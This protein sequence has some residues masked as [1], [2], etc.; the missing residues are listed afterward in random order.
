MGGR[1]RLLC[2]IDYE[3]TRTNNA[4]VVKRV[5]IWLRR[6]NAIALA[7][8]DSVR[9]KHCSCWELIRKLVGS[10]SCGNF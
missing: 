4:V 5:N 9:D 6:I 8:D 7:G 2:D 1:S 3:N 10:S